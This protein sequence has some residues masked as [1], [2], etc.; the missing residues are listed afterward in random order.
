M[1]PPADADFDEKVAAA[2]QV[3]QQAPERNAQGERTV[4]TDELTGVQVLERKH[5]GL[6]MA[7]GKVERREFE[8]IRHGTLSFIL[9]RDGVTGE[10]VAPTAGATRTEADF[11]AHV[12]SV[13]ATNPTATRWH[14]VVDNLNIHLSASLVR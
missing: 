13:V 2:C 10:V 3:Y 6:P 5:P 7:A 9:S 12:Q 1:T 8:Y 14:F 11:L 4:S